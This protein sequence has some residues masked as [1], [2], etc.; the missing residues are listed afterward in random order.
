MPALPDELAW[1]LADTIDFAGPD[2]NLG[3]LLRHPDTVRFVANFFGD[4]GYYA[5]AA[6]HNGVPIRA[7][8]M[9]GLIILTIGCRYE[10]D[11]P[12]AQVQLCAE[13]AK[14]LA[15]PWRY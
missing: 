8:W 9:A 12:H 4:V 6:S 13:R 1:K 3:S 10:P 5:V 15:T 14:R 11:L 2:G 7:E